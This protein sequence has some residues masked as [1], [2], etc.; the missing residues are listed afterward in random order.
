[1]AITINKKPNEFNG[2]YNDNN[3]YISSDVSGVLYFDVK[4]YSIDDILVG[5]YKYYKPPTQNDVNISFTQLLQN[6]VFTELKNGNNLYHHLGGD[7]K[8]YLKITGL[9]A[10]GVI[11]EPELTTEIFTVIDAYFDVFD[12]YDAQK[13]VID[14]IKKAD[15][16]T[17]FNFD[18]PQFVNVNQPIFYYLY[19]T[20]EN[21]NV[22]LNFTLN[23]VINGFK[24]VEIKKGLNVLK[25]KLDELITSTPL[26]SINL[27]QFNLQI[28][29]VEITNKIRL[30]IKKSCE[31]STLSI[32]YKNKKG[33]FDSLSIE[34]ASLKLLKNS[35]KISFK[36][37]NQND[38]KNGVYA[39][40]K[41]VI[42]VKE[43]FQYNVTTGFLTKYEETI[44][45]HIISS[46][47]AYIQ[48]PDGYLLPIEILNNNL[49]ISY[50][51]KEKRKI[52]LIFTT[53]TTSFIN[54]SKSEIMNRTATQQLNYIINN[55][56]SIVNPS[57]PI[58]II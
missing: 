56:H 8:Y 10:L 41:T 2:A 48:L 54:D 19:S 51:T 5:K 37:N 13:Y 50:K 30:G 47:E 29:D 17:D 55:F 20:I 16:L 7:F 25:I 4:I 15:F 31:D 23:A 3:F 42:S 40:N 58:T 35:S 46:P 28:D 38:I 53:K 43:E 11:I 24:K 32:V 12:S 44:H 1:M 36:N 9:N 6:F 39:N 33:G 45:S 57:N 18:N 14:G 27:F 34:K 52:N 21:T 26:S 22:N 49:N